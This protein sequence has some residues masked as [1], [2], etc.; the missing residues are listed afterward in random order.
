MVCFFAVSRFIHNSQLF[1][2]NKFQQISVISRSLTA[3]LLQVTRR[4][5]FS[6]GSTRG[7]VR[8]SFCCLP[9]CA[10]VGTKRE[11]SWRL[12]SS[13]PVH[14][15]WMDHHHR[16]AICGHS[17]QTTVSSR[18]HCAMVFGVSL[19]TNPSIHPWNRE[20][21]ARL[22]NKQMRRDRERRWQLAQKHMP[23]RC[24]YDWLHHGQDHSAH[25][26]LKPRSCMSCRIAGTNQRVQLSLSV[27]CAPCCRP[28][29]ALATPNPL[30]LLAF[31]CE[32]RGKKQRL[33]HKL[34]T[35]ILSSDFCHL[36]L[37]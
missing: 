3:I 22:M 27:P 26:F 8:G 4:K 15:S 20:Q 1:Q 29:V 18:G 19:T 14:S 23:H 13:L 5:R 36:F 7:N 30:P 2:P 11:N 9:N 25:Q 35:I 32:T 17:I 16:G 34:G 31:E 10:D 37:A 28:S 6:E 24:L 33:L 21:P 12:D